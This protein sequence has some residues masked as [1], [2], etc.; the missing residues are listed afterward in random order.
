MVQFWS[1][2]SDDVNKV[3]NTNI[4]PL[5]LHF[6]DTLMGVGVWCG[7]WVCGGECVWGWVCVCVC[8][9]ES[10]NVYEQ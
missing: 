1:F 2:L 7:G 4:L 3:I 5:N 8:V 6:K 9:C 10:L